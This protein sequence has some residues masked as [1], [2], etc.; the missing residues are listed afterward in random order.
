MSD[1]FVSGGMFIVSKHFSKKEILT[2]PNLLS[3]IRLL[4]IP[5]IVRLCLNPENR[6][7]ALLLLLLSGATDIADGFI[8]RRYHQVSDFGKIL[9]PLA[10]K[11]T[12]AA[13]LLCLTARYPLMLPLIL[14]F[15]LRE[16]IMI[17]LGAAAI[18]KHSAVNSAQWY[19]KAATVTI[20][21]T[22]T[23]LI[24]FPS[25]S[26]TAANLL[27]LL[28]AC[29]MLLSLVLYIRFYLRFF[30]QQQNG[31]RTASAIKPPS[32]AN[33]NADPFIQPKEERVSRKSS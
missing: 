26:Q 3:L 7:A 19:G 28:C 11:L 21:T 6:F 18:K 1:P 23:L 31:I 14:F 33:D 32:P 22:M 10:D 30:S 29:V 16:I 13:L 8:A 15:A 20:Y 12:Q 2:L 17:S 9:D 27:I 25:L 5:P 4:L 24:L